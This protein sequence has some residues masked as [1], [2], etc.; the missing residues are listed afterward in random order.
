MLHV[1][2]VQDPRRG[3]EAGDGQHDGHL[4]QIQQRGQEVQS[5]PHQASHR[6]YRR[7]HDTQQSLAGEEDQTP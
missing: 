5:D 7:L 6:H 1:T 4:L 3:A 2:G